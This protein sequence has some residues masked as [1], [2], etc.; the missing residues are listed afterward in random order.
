MAKKKPHSWRQTL[1]IGFGIMLAFGVWHTTFVKPKPEFYLT[2]LYDLSCIL[3]GIIGSV[4]IWLWPQKDKPPKKRSDSKSIHATCPGCQTAYTFGERLHGKKVR[5]KKCGQVF[6]VKKTASS[7]PEFD[8]AEDDVTDTRNRRVLILALVGGGLTLFVGAVLLSAVLFPSLRSAVREQFDSDFRGSWPVPTPPAGYGAGIAE[9]NIVTLHVAG[10]AD[11][12]AQDAIYGKATA[13]A[14]DGNASFICA[15]REGNRM[16]VRL[17]IVRDPQ[18]CADKIDFGT[19]RR[20]SGRTISVVAHTVEGPAPDADV[21]TRTLFDLKSPLASR[22][23]EAARRLKTMAPNERRA[24]VAR[25]L[26]EALMKD[27]NPFNRTEIM[28]AL[29]VWGTKDS[30]P[31]LLNALKS[32]ENHD[33]FTRQA[34]FRALA[35][36]RDERACEPIALYLEDLPSRH[37]AAEALKA[38]GPIAEKAVLK[39]LENPDPFLRQQVCE[40]L[41]VIGTKESLPALKRVASQNDF[42]VSGPAQS[43]IQAI[44]AR[45]K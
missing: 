42:V 27:T 6:L 19:V 23:E 2:R 43:A 37:D 45:R 38:M 7:S 30:V 18:A 9:D 17:G 10:V 8:E 14:D 36:F 16:T 32:L 5:C 39:R 35:R 29:E 15:A 4:V 26:V 24:E 34:I 40:I 31:G 25:A 41:A 20:I 28:A 12:I 3:I 11:E 1:Q 22:R 21:V 33:V 13:L 44:Q